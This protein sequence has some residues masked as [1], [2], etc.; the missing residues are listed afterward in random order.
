MSKFI[1]T[2]MKVRNA[3]MTYICEMEG[4]LIINLELNEKVLK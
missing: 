2:N 4:I 3:R 1:N